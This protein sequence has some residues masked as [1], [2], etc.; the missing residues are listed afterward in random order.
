MGLSF[1]FMPQIFSSFLDLYMNAF[2]TFINITYHKKQE[3]LS[4]TFVLDNN[5]PLYM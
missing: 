5:V 3:L 4:D 1:L 2:I